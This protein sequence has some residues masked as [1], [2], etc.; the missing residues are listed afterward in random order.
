SYGLTDNQ[1]NQML[2]ESMENARQDVTN[3]ILSETKVK[4]QTLIDKTLGNL[5]EDPEIL[6][7]NE[8]T[9]LYETIESLKETLGQ[10]DRDKI[11]QT[12]EELE[13][14]A[15]ELIGRKL[16]KY[17]NNFKGKK[18]EDIE[19]ILHPLKNDK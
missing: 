5:K 18:L 9:K 19:K 10:N 2:I 16:D 8:Q 3:R 7:N 17:L 14:I 12:Q 13:I 1:I 11:L 6:N 15:K 4:A